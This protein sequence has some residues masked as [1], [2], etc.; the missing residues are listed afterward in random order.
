MFCICSQNPLEFLIPT[1]TPSPTPRPSL[2]GRWRPASSNSCFYDLIEFVDQ[3]TIV[4]QAGPFSSP[5][6]YKILDSTRF[7]ASTS[8]G[9]SL[10]TY[11]LSGDRLTISACG[12]F[13]SCDLV[14]AK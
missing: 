5:G 13:V 9:V 2:V 11:K 8:A 6:T 14:R 10:W 3:D 4:F 1:A 12:G 7:Q